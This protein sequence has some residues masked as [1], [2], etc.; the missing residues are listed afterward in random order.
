MSFAEKSVTFV[1]MQVCPS[2][3]IIKYLICHHK[4]HLVSNYNPLL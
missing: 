3:N 2:I 1:V 4:R